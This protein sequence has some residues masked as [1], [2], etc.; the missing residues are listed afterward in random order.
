M[1]YPYESAVIKEEV[2]VFALIT[3]VKYV[4]MH[5][6]DRIEL[7]LV[8]KGQIHVYVGREEYVLKENDLLLINSNEVHGVESDQENKLLLIQIPITFIKKFHN[9]I[10]DESFHCQSFQ[11]KDQQSYNIIRPLLAH[12][13]LAV[14]RKEENYE[15]KVHSLL[16][17]VV[18]QLVTHFK[19]DKKNVIINTEKDIERMNR[20]TNYIQQHYMNPITLQELADTEEL[21]APYLSRYFQ[22]HMGQSFIKYINGIRLEHAVRYLLE[23]D[24]S[25]IQIALECGFPNLNSFHKLFK[26][27]FHTTPHQYR[28]KQIQNNTSIRP[29]ELS[30]IRGY[31]FTEEEDYHELY[32]LL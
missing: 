18:Y 29:A 7:L 2:P 26:D 32:K 24:R 28:K 11:S 20:L 15:I 14:K 5:W 16:L 17:D 31:E 6:H 4:A 21:T 25:I 23:T 1:K 19:V 13:M 30:E 10:E 3:S 12:L 22:H 9:N 27:T 8:L